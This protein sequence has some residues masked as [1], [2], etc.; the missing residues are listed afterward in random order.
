MMRATSSQTSGNKS[1]LPRTAR[2]A[3]TLRGGCRSRSWPAL[4][5]GALRGLRSTVATGVDPSGYGS[6]IRVPLLAGYP[7]GAAVVV[8][9]YVVVGVQYSRFAGDNAHSH[10]GTGNKLAVARN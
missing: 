5:L 8:N 9:T 10:K 4:K 2:S 6:D 3:S 1:R 7:L